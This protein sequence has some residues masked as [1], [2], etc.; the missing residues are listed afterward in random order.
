MTVSSATVGDLFA[1]RAQTLVNTVNCVGVMGKG[2]ALGFKQRFPGMYRDYV[3]RCRRHEV[4][5]GRPYLY[6]EVIAPWILNFPTKDHWRAVSRLSDIADGLEYLTKHYKA[7]G[8]TSLAVPPLGCGN[9][10]LDWNVIGPTLYRY[11][12]QLDIPVEM[13]APNDTPPKQLTAGF[14]SRGSD[15]DIGDARSVGTRLP[16]EAIALV[17]VVSRI[18]RERHHW[19]VGRTTFQKIAYFLTESGVPTGLRY[20]RGSYGPFSPEIKRLIGSLMNHN[21]VVEQRLGRMFEITPGPTYADARALYLDKLRTWAPT[22]E[23][24]ADLFLR[25]PGTHEAELAATVHFTAKDLRQTTQ[26]RPTE[27]EVLDAVKRWKV[28]RRP[29]L[30]ERDVADTIRNLNLLGWIDV[31]ASPDLPVG[32]DELLYA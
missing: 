3:E 1:S 20:Q 19:P 27:S 2:V 6:K 24:V 15:S 17:G 11:L 16:P 9:G 7:W 21:I 12:D 13:Y 22:I 5:L 10:Q 29:P 25:M 26:K 18:A 8:I 31:E 14:L 4:R 28:R 32:A 30:E 23:Q